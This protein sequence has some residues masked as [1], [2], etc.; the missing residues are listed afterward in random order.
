M[1][2]QQS[3]LFESG[4]VVPL[5]ENHI[6]SG[7]ATFSTPKPKV[8]PPKALGG[9]NLSTPKPKVSPPKAL[10]GTILSTP[11]PKVSPPKALGGT[12]CHSD[13]PNVKG[14]RPLG[15]TICRIGGSGGVRPFTYWRFGGGR[16]FTEVNRQPPLK[17]DQKVAPQNHWGLGGPYLWPKAA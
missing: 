13:A 5:W 17:P 10:G 12:I 7:P 3:F 14:S 11:K 9:T 16:L 2:S 4:L 1:A 15:V 8:L 6:P